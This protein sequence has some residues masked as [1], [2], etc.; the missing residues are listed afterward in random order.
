MGS[1]K[2]AGNLKCFHGLLGVVSSA[3]SSSGKE[4]VQ[5][6]MVSEADGVHLISSVG[7]LQG[8]VWQQGLTAGT[9]TV[10]RASSSIRSQSPQQTHM[11]V[12]ELKLA[13]SHT[14]VWVTFGDA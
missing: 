2:A 14:A 6:T 13:C 4:L 8:H 12:L 3:S 11:K 1:G 7:Q 10:V 5:A 9:L